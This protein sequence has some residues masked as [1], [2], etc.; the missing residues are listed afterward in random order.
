[1]GL[2]LQREGW[3]E[4]EGLQKV[5]PGRYTE[6][7][8]EAPGFIPLGHRDPWPGCPSAGSMARSH[9]SRQSDFCAL[10]RQAYSWCERAPTTLATTHYA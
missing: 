5:E 1:M 2:G 3:E 9:G 8:A 10:Q 4:R 6:R 7:L